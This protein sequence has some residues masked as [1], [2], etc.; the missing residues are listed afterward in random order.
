MR[1]FLRSGIMVV[2]AVLVVVVAVVGLRAKHGLILLI[3][4]LLRATISVVDAVA[5][6]AVRVM[7]ARGNATVAASSVFVAALSV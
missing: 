4:T 5:V 2:V 7:R 6:A 3:S 1:D